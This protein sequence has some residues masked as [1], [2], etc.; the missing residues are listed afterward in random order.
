MQAISWAFKFIIA[1][2]FVMVS[3]SHGID[4]G[5]W[6]GILIVI[7]LIPTGGGGKDDSEAP[8]DKPRARQT[9]VQNK[10]IGRK[11]PDDN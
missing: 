7:L 3:L 2:I 11:A 10:I 5:I 1:V 8:E 9:K 6:V 4:M